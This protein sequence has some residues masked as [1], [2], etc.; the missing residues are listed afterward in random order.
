MPTR[1]NPA[2][3]DPQEINPT[4]MDVGD[5]HRWADLIEQ[6]YGNGSKLFVAAKLRQAE[7]RGHSVLMGVWRRIGEVID[8]EYLHKHH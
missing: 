1:T 2:Q 3:R 5:V 7:Q 4:S 8:H 6:Q